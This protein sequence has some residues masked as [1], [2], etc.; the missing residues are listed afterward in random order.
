[1]EVMVMNLFKNL[2]RAFVAIGCMAQSGRAAEQR[3]P[4]QN[5]IGYID[6]FQR[7]LPGLSAHAVGVKNAQALDQKFGIAIDR[8]LRQ[9]NPAVQVQIDV[10]AAQ[11][12]IPAVPAPVDGQQVVQPVHQQPAVVPAPILAV[13]PAP[14]PAAAVLA[15][16]PVRAEDAMDGLGEFF[17]R[18][19]GEAL[20]QVPAQRAQQPIAPVPAIVVQPAAQIPVPAVP[21]PVDQQ[22][23]Q[24]VHQ[25]GVVPAPI[26]AV[27]PAPA[28][29]AVVP[30]IDLQPAAQIPVAAVARVAQS[31]Q[32]ISQCVKQFLCDHGLALSGPCL[33][34]ATEL[35]MR[36]GC[37]PLTLFWKTILV[38][39]LLAASGGL[40]VWKEPEVQLWV[41][42]ILYLALQYL[43]LVDVVSVPLA[44]AATS[45][46][47]HR[48]E[49]LK[50]FKLALKPYEWLKDAMKFIKENPKTTYTI[51][52]AGA[53]MSAFLRKIDLF[54]DRM[55][56]TL[57]T[58]LFVVAL[59]THFKK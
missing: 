32:S 47:L 27:A 5:Q 23:V 15:A 56:A 18:V 31:G 6:L 40:I 1:M 11:I 30:A 57:V 52:A 54:S 48:A 21:A 35:W 17:V 36:S 7:T 12:P 59:L 24:P 46:A 50:A 20:A 4:A 44:A 43:G 55:T 38:P 13:A 33:L 45:I 16:D 8:C 9:P 10:P 37:V 49:L 19:E 2:L 26:P 14:A 53:L 39:T 22:V 29:A 3:P 34:V 28:P 51:V 41:M 42:A 58:P 25:P